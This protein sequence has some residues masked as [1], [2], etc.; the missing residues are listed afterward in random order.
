MLEMLIYSMIILGDV[1]V[2][3]RLSAQYQPEYV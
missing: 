2:A 1:L 3:C